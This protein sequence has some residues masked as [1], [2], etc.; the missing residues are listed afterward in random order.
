MDSFKRAQADHSLSACA[1]LLETHRRGTPTTST[2]ATTACASLCCCA[3][4][5]PA[6]QLLRLAVYVLVGA[7]AGSRCLLACC[8]GTCHCCCN[9]N[10]EL[11]RAGRSPS[12]ARRR[13]GQPETH[14]HNTTTTTATK[15][16]SAPNH[17]ASKSSNSRTKIVV[18]G[19]VSHQGGLS[20][21]DR[22]DCS[23]RHDNHSAPAMLL[24]ARPSGVHDRRADVLSQ[25]RSRGVLLR[26]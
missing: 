2:C 18:G 15:T 25:R 24:R 10:R 12:N 7:R 11:S 5:I 16:N 6:L 1:I 20:S 9:S 22:V 21:G 19:G 17:G 13:H 14:H 26:A 23:P 3:T 8:V 4:Y